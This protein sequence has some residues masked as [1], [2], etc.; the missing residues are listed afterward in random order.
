MGNKISKLGEK[1]FGERRGSERRKFGLAPRYPFYDSNEVLVKA[2]RR[3]VVDRRMQTFDAS[4]EILYLYLSYLEMSGVLEP[5]GVTVTLG[6]DR[7][8]D[9]RIQTEFSS[10]KH[11]TIS[12]RGGR[13]QIEDH[14]RNGTYIIL[15][16]ETE[17]HITGAKMELY[18]SGSISLG[19]PRAYAGEDIIQFSTRSS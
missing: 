10:R 19:T 6:R 1:I 16:D 2:N 12:F 18:G 3:R 15:E 4:A 14:S 7:G 9:L 17:L 5:S 13:Y 8:C 11:A